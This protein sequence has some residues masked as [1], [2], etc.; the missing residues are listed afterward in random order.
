[1]HAFPG[2]EKY[3][4]Y[5]TP[6]H[7]DIWAVDD[8]SFDSYVSMVYFKE[9]S[10][11][12]LIEQA[13]GKSQGNTALDIAGGSNGRAIADMINEGYIGKGAFTNLTDKRDL[14]KNKDNISFLPGDLTLEEN[15]SSLKELQQTIA[16]NGFDIALHRP[17][18]GLQDLAP[19]MYI[20]GISKILD[21]LRKRG[22][23]YAQIPVAPYETPD[24]DALNNIFYAIR[25]MNQVDCIALS[26]RTR[27]LSDHNF[28]LIYKR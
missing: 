17:Y 2:D 16:P 28:C 26:D 14:S 8:S 20:G 19:S 10:A 21:L 6:E 15:W 11:L 1:M 13:I 9:G 22:I 23:L 25:N 4:D 7:K 5:S 12:E 27:T 3:P 24:Y 18:G